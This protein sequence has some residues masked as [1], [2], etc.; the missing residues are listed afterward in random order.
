[1][2]LIKIML[3]EYFINFRPFKET[4]LVLIFSLFLGFAEIHH[5]STSLLLVDIKRENS[6]GY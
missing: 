1:M 6:F 5:K 2:I 4:L 3:A